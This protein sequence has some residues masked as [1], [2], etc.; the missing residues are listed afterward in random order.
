MAW[1][2]KNPIQEIQNEMEAKQEQERQQLENNFKQ[3]Q[4][5]VQKNP[6]DINKIDQNVIKNLWEYFASNKK[7]ATHMLFDV[8]ESLKDPQNKLDKRDEKS[9]N[10]IKDFIIQDKYSDMEKVWEYQLNKDIFNQDFDFSKMKEYWSFFQSWNTNDWFK[11]IPENYTDW[12]N[13][14]V[15]DFCKDKYFSQSQFVK[16]LF[17][18]NTERRSEITTQLDKADIVSFL[19]DDIHQKTTQEIIESIKDPRDQIWKKFMESFGSMDGYREY[20][21]MISQNNDL[22]SKR[23]KQ[24][25]NLKN[26]AEK[27]D[28]IDDFSMDRSKVT[29]PEIKKFNT[30]SPNSKFNEIVDVIKQ[31]R[32]NPNSFKLIE[33]LNTWDLKWFQTEVYWDKLN[34]SKFKNDWKFGQETLRLTKE[35]LVA[36]IARL[37]PRTL[38]NSKIPSP[39]EMLNYNSKSTTK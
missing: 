39:N 35:Y 30:E 10:T 25:N 34:E 26:E 24:I 23:E 4:E 5:D 38:D 12:S 19:E 18:K 20:Q 16:W 31:N 11:N 29:D 22:I 2:E 33:Y 13:P 27:K 6:E 15:S 37:E 7:E 1:P 36:P 17:N 9:L 14:K 32:D 21:D 8:L 28:K 3:L